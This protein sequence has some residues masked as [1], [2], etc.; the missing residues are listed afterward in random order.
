MAE[1]RKLVTVVFSDV[2]GSTSL[3]EQLDA[4]ALR[5]VMG[6]YF[7]ETRAILEH[8][9]GT[10]EKFIGDAVMAVFGIPA[11]HEDDALRA[12][13]AASEMRERLAKLNE[14]FLRERGVTL[15]VRIG[16][17]TGEVVA[18]DPSEGQFYA[19]G[20]AVNVAARLEQAARSGEI[21]LGKQTYEL[22]GDAVTVEALEPLTVR[23][24]SEPV[25]AY[26]LLE[27]IEGAPAFARR[28]DT[29]F[30]GREEP[31]AHL[32]GCFERAVAER[33]PALVTVLGPAGIGKTRLAAEFAR[34]IEEQATVLQGR[35]LSYGEGITFW[36]LQEILRSLGERPAEAPDP[37]QARSVEETFWAYRKLFEA[38]AHQ[39]PLIIILED[40]HWA[41][42]TLLDLVEHVAEWTRDAP[43]VLLCLA[44]PELLDI[45]PQWRG[46]LLELETLSRTETALLAGKLDVEVEPTIRERSAELAEG[47]PLFLEQLLALALEEKGTELALP[48]TIQ[49]LLAAR[50]D[51]LGTEE[52]ALLE[53]AAVVG[54]EFWRSA[55]AHL[56]PPQT[57]VSALLQRLVRKRL[58]R[59]ERSTFPGEDAFRFAHILIRDAA[60]GATAKEHRAELH[61]GF[62][63]WLN[64][65]ESPYHEIIG[66]HL[67]QAYRFRAELGPSDELLDALA[68]RAAE[69][70]STAGLRA[71]DRADYAAA[72]NL[73]GR[74]VALLPR[75]NPL[76][77]S[78]LPELGQSLLW[79]GQYPEARAALAE[80]IEDGLRA[81]DGA[82]EWRARLWLA[83][84]EAQ[85]NPDV[86]NRELE[87][88]GREALA[89]FTERG[90]A[91]GKAMAG[92]MIA[93]ALNWQFRNAPAALVLEEALRCAR[94][95]GDQLLEAAC[96]GLLSRALVDGPTPIAQA[97]DRIEDLLATAPSH[98][99]FIE[100]VLLSNL[101]L[102][103]CGQGR[104]DEARTL[105]RRATELAEEL[106]SEIDVATMAAFHGATLERS[107]GNL[108]AAEAA[109]RRGDEVLAR[110]GET[111]W[112][113]TVAVQLASVLVAQDKI[114]E[115]EEYLRI[116][117]QAAASDDFASQV[118]LRLVRARISANRGELDEAERLVRD[119]LLLLHGTDDI[120]AQADASLKLAKVLGA[121]GRTDEAISA[122][123]TALQ[124]CEQKGNVVM[125]RETRELLDELEVGSSTAQSDFPS[126]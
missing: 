47:N 9:G 90:D 79:L 62:A 5:R 108:E 98:V 115:G 84:L 21:L 117:E 73:L 48:R 54:K 50:L 33:T 8:H 88:T 30:V 61:E 63:D 42:P 36:P 70:L 64:A 86:S 118:P 89:V 29:P 6:R 67:E 43:A 17:N 103:C 59:P 52:R 41:Q 58:I 93:Q 69:A 49:G 109:L 4:E 32:R 65:N 25:P 116:S 37:E 111:G 45:R 18:G 124:L 75:G 14:E 122:A 101:V 119:A 95:A 22:V 91:Q 76:R 66:Y 105:F 68:R 51:Q 81:A 38:L 44:R 87:L 60:Y 34:E 110:L 85:L 55:L 120:D 83:R 40:I 20:D 100:R 125:C 126:P 1:A 82:V 35:C 39:R 112:R 106:G 26:R 94:F 46:E 114:E 123:E 19:S 56:S 107:A 97:I 12:V 7:A 23:G 99:Q 104:L 113:S 28:F 3:G 10:V 71:R 27:L 102:L 11:A 78:L 92:L 72:A 24:K 96:I 31:L 74:A 57:E 16:I 121:A 77:L 2:A 53:R 13:R 80:A 15:A